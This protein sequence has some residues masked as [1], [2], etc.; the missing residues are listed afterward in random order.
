MPCV[1]LIETSRDGKRRHRV[2]FL[3]VGN[4]PVAVKHRGRT[5]LFEWTAASGWMAVNKNGSERLSRVPNVVWD[6]VSELRKRCHLCGLVKFTEE[7]ARTETRTTTMYRTKRD[8]MNNANPVI[9]QKECP[10]CL[11]CAKAGTG[12]TGGSGR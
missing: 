11:E 4:D 5:Y 10:I 3:C 2:G 7:I 6:K 8:A 9:V 12:D 1:P